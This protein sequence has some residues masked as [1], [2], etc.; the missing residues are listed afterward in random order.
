MRVEG[1]GFGVWSFRVLGFPGLGFGMFG[2][3]GMFGT[4][5]SGFRGLVWRRAK[6]SGG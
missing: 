6:R 1:L 3:F 5:G 2:M 4:L